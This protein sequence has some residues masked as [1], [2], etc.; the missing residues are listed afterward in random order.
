[1]IG[2]VEP[3]G[4]VGI[5]QLGEDTVE[6]EL[7]AAEQLGLARAAQQAL[8]PPQTPTTPRYDVYVCGR[9]RRIDFAATVTFSALILGL[10]ALMGW[11]ALP[12]ATAATP[13]LV[14]ASPVTAAPIAQAQPGP[15]IMQVINPFDSTE[16][17]ELPADAT[18]AEAKE[19]IAF[20]VLA[21]QTLF[22]SAGNVPAVT[23]AAGPRVLGKI[24]F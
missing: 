16:V 19:A 6:F 9:T 10:T 4:A 14:I 23:G 15:G 1:M 8:R 11:R 22:G 7:T 18:E 5:P 20:A 17:F 2:G 3:P 13:A 21:N 24:S 12:G